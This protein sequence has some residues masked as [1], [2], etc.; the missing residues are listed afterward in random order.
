MTKTK[1]VRAT[2]TDRQLIEQYERE[3]FEQDLTE[4]ELI[5]AALS[6]Y[7]AKENLITSE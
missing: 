2:I 3:L 7:L 4:R 5:E 6:L 1:P